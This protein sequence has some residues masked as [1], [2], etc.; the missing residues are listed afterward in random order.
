MKENRKP[1]YFIMQGVLSALLCY[2]SLVSIYISFIKNKQ[3]DLLTFFWTL[4]LVVLAGLAVYKCYKFIKKYHP[5]PLFF[6]NKTFL[7]LTICFI[8]LCIGFFNVST[9]Y[10]RE[11]KISE[12]NQ[13]MNSLSKN[14]I[15]DSKRQQQ[16]PLDYYFSSFSQSL[17]GDNKFAVRFHA[18]FFYLLLSLI[19]PL[20]IYFFC[21]SVWITIIGPCYLTSI[22]SSS[23]MQLLP[24]LSA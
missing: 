8:N 12:M 23:Y 22:M 10:S 21:S 6:K 13:F 18:M 24:D 9:Q 16:P 3:F 15:E 11:F 5:P 7:L 4:T 1:L 19:L 14:V 17:F 20:G 2:A